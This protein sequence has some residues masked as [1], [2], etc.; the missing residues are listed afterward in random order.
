M[1]IRSLVLRD[2]GRLGQGAWRRMGIGLGLGGRS[3]ALQGT[4]APAGRSA[5]NHIDARAQQCAKGT[6]LR[7]HLSETDEFSGQ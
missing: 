1:A 7:K 2:A 4:Q 6:C 5:L 3:V